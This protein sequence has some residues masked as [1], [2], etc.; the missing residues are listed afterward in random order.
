MKFPIDAVF[1]DGNN[2]VIAVT[3]NIL[4]N[5]MTRVFFNAVSVLELPP[6]T[7]EATATKT[8]DEVTL[9]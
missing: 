1:L 3:R 8:G 4:P 7:I 9:V 6:G 5:R 2:R